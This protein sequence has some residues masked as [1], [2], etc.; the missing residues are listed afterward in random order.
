MAR[1]YAKDALLA[2]GRPRTYT[3]RTLDRISFPLGGIGTGS[4]GLTG[5]GGLKDW[6]IFNRPNVGGT[7]PRTFPLIWAKAQG[8]EP[9]CRILEAPPSPP[10]QGSGGGDPCVNGEGMPHMDGAVFRGEYPFAWIDFASKRLPVSVRLEAYNPFIPSNPDDSGFPVAVLRYIVKNES[11][12][13]VE[14]TVAWSMLNMIGS[15]GVAGNDP[16]LGKAVEHGY[17]KNVNTFVD[18]QGLR[19]LLFSSIK[20]PEGHPRFGNMALVTPERSV[21]VLQYWPRETWFT[22]MHYFWDTFSAKGVFENHDLGPSPDGQTDA[23]ALGVRMRLQ[24]GQTKTIAF[25]FAWYFPVF[26]KYWHPS[27]PP[28][29]EAAIPQ[30]SGKPLWRNYYAARFSSAFDAALK[31]YR[32]EKVLYGASLRSTLPPHVLDAVASNMAI[33]KTATCIRLPDGTFYGF[34]GSMPGAGSCEG[35]CTHV[36]NYQQALPFLFPSLERSM[37]E[38]D[39]RYNLR[40]DGRMGFRIQLPLGSPPWEFQACA[41]GQMGG[42]IKTYRDWKISGDDAWMRSLWPRVQRALEYAW[43]AWDPDKDGVMTEFQ[44][45]T[46]DIEFL[47]PNPMMACLYLGALSAAAEMAAHV[48]ESEKAQ[49]YRAIRDKG[50]AWVEAN[51]FNGKYYVQHYD[52]GQ[53]PKYQFGTGCLSDQ[54]FGQWMTS[55]AGL[56]YVLDPV[57]VRKALRSVFRHNWRADLSEHANAQRVYALDG[58]A[59]LLLCSWPSGGRPSVPFPY[60]DEVWT[61]IEYQVAS[62]LIMEGMAAEAMHIVKGARDRH[63]GHKRNPWNEF[64]CGNHYARAM[65]SYGLLT[66]LSGFRFDLGEGR[67]GFDPKIRTNAFSSFWAVDGAW[68]VFRQNQKTAVLEVLYG[69]LKL[70]ELIL[71]GFARRGDEVTAETSGRAMRIQ[72][73]GAGL[74][75]F[76]RQVELKAGRLLRMQKKQKSK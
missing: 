39:Y 75:R 34:E 38:A 14:A 2:P 76:E 19:G 24:P 55:L 64:E 35:S 1:G 17:G 66:A 44:H 33:L 41:D 36:W 31:L 67:L 56:D 60:S 28:S 69:A 47:G 51:L 46:Y 37:R 10:Y 27:P 52:P 26:E 13:R 3:G 50:R 30:S 74:I 65:S 5:H 48:G 22:P 20:W 16:V 63:D 53:A 9:V 15:I 45:N 73:D 70:R 7:F 18:R 72:T 49:E 57:R 6:E 58:E 59:G 29:G 40:E 11:S 61:G 32:R 21:T 68:G 12:K 62:H 8:E 4:V 43:T 54:V 71:P 42:V 23:G 25:Y